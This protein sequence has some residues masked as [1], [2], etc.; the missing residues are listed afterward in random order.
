MPLNSI[1]WCSVVLIIQSF[2]KYK[3]KRKDE[4]KNH[5]VKDAV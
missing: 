3:K 2:I 5:I 4:E 1:Y